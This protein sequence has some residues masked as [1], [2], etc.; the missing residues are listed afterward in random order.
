MTPRRNFGLTWWGRAWAEALEGRA[1]L[2][3]NRLPRGRTYARKGRVSALDVTA[4]EVRAWVQ[5]SRSVPYRVTVRVRVFSAE[6]WEVLLDKVVARIGHAAA[7]LD[8][9]LPE[10]LAGDLLPGPGEL[11]PRCSCPDSADPCKHSAAVCYLV[12]DEVDAD[13]FVLFLLRG[14]AREPLLRE[15][16]ARRRRPAQVRDVPVEQGLS[17]RDAFARRV[18]AVPLLPPA[19]AAPGPPVVLTEPPAESSLQV[20]VLSQLAAD[21][22]AHAYDLLGGMAGF[23]LTAEEDLARRA[24]RGDVRQLASAAGMP[25]AE[26]RRWAAAWRAA[27]SGGLAALRE[28]WQPPG[29]SLAEARAAV[30]DFPGETKVWRNRVTRG[31]LQLR[32]GRDERWYLFRRTS[33]G[34]VP[35]GPGYAHPFDALTA[36]QRW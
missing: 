19:P 36:D 25:V 26:L 31:D 24:A 4:G 14:R 11:R 2:D 23:S 5:G 12:A 18:A 16:R 21:A 3:P 10:E 22:A 20:S 27:G 8:G 33:D 17:P 32:L 6:Q 9:E 29:M 7:L 15:L 30:E 35:A 34:R 13:P 1:K 28:T